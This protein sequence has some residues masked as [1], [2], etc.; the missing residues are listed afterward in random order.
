MY[1]VDQFESAFRSA[2]KE[3]FHYRRF[4]ISSVLVVTDL[5]GEAAEQF[6]SV[7]ERF[8]AALREHGEVSYTLITGDRF[9]SPKDLLDIVEKQRPDLIATYRCLHS[10]AWQWVF[11]LG[12][13]IDVLTQATTT[14]VLLLPHPNRNDGKGPDTGTVAPGQTDRVMAVTDHLAGD[15]QL[16]NAALAFAEPKGTLFLSHV[17]DDATFERYMTTI[18]KLPEIDTDMA[19]ERIQQQLLKEPHDYIGSV[20][21]ALRAGNVACTVNEIVQMGHHVTQYKE[22]VEA[23][24]VDLL[25]MNTKDEDHSAMHGLAYPLAVELRDTPLLML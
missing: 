2:S 1:K 6:K 19:R 8:T 10:K 14:P 24:E 5:E 25:V 4:A 12:A 23:H 7:V 15:E 20:A 3:V 18:S 21:A 13:H 16:V 17:E 22:M 9:A 11:T